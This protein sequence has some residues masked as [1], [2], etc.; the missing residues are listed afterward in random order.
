MAVAGAEDGME[1][2]GHISC[3]ADGAV[4]PAVVGHIGDTS[5]RLFSG[6]SGAHAVG[7]CCH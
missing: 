6:A 7:Q 4:A 5:E 2:R 1:G 3:Y